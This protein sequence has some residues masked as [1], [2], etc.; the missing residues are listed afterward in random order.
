M[1]K[2]HRE[3]LHIWLITEQFILVKEKKLLYLPTDVT[4]PYHPNTRNYSVW[5]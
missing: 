1:N 3:E 4:P 2:T 5:N